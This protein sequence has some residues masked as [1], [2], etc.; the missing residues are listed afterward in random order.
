MAMMLVG[1]F[2]EPAAII[3]VADPEIR[4]V[5]EEAR[6]DLEAVGEAT[7]AQFKRRLHNGV[8]GG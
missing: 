8:P 6:A 7:K 3:A 4:A 5:L 1:S 2:A